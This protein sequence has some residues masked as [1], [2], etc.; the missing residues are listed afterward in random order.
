MLEEVKK[1]KEYYSIVHEILESEEFQKRQDFLHHE[2]ESVFDHVLEVSYFAYLYCKDHKLDYK[3]AAIGGL[4]HDFYPKPWQKCKKKKKQFFD[5]HGYVHAKEALENAWYYFPQYMTPKIQNIILRH[6]FP[7]NLY[8][9]KYKE[10]WAVTMIDKR[11]SMKVFHKPTGLLKYVGIR[12]DL[13]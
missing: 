10:A 1:D 4:L 7:L 6:M 5:M 9:P 13:Q 8:P 11:V 3:S 12:K 2:G